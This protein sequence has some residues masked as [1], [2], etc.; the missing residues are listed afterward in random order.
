MKT[1]YEVIVG[2]IGQVYDG[3]SKR[4]AMACFHQYVDQSKAIGF[5]A[6]GEPVTLLADGDIS[7]EYAC[8]ST[9]TANPQTTT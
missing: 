9:T 3:P 4:A 2:N 5:R 8:I 6:S 1:N 7:R